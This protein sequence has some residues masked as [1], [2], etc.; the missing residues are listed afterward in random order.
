MLVSVTAVDILFGGYAVIL[1][2]P[3]MA[4]VSTLIDVT[5]RNRD[6]AAEDVPTVLFTAKDAEAR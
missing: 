2:I 1:A 5:V 4:I 3:L 6:P